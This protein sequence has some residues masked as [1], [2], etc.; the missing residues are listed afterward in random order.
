MEFLILP[1]IVFKNVVFTNISKC[2]LIVLFVNNKKRLI[3]C[4]SNI[5]KLLNHHLWMYNM[6]YGY[7][8]IL[9]DPLSVYI[10]FLYKEKSYIEMILLYAWKILFIFFHDSPYDPNASLGNTNPS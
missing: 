4:S 5:L 8:N 10:T 3:Y 2:S 1:I 7:Q 6:F 9:W